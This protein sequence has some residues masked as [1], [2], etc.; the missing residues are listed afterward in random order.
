MSRQQRHDFKVA[1]LPIS[2][3]VSTRLMAGSNPE[4]PDG[5]APVR[6]PTQWCGPPPCSSVSITSVA[7]ASGSCAEESWSV[8]GLLRASLSRA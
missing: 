2:Y 6:G 5:I 7:W 3:L 4:N 1:P 8:P